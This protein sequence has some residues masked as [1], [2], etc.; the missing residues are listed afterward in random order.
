MGSAAAIF[1][2]CGLAISAM[3]AFYYLV[4]LIGRIA[5]NNYKVI[6]TVNLVVWAVVLLA[7]M[8]YNSV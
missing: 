1:I 5:Y 3:F 2:V 8:I 7:S 4:F 6:L